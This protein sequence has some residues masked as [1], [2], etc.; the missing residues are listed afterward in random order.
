MFSVQEIIQ[1][2]QAEPLHIS[3]PNTL[4]KHLLT[5]SR[6]AFF[7]EHTLFIA[8]KG[9][10]HNAHTF[11]PYLIEKGITNFLVSENIFLSS[12]QSQS[13]NLLKVPNTLQAL[14]QIAQAH[15]Q[16]FDYPVIAITGS[17]GKTIVK[18]WLTEL[19]SP[20][21]NVVKS[22]KSYNSQVG[23]PLSVWHMTH[24]H[25]LAIFEAGISMPN[26]MQ[27]LQ[28]ILQPDIGIFTNIGEAH[29]EGF[30]NRTHKIYEKY[31]LFQH[32]PIVFSINQDL[33]AQKLPKL[34][35]NFQVIS[36]TTSAQKK[37]YTEVKFLD[38]QQFLHTLQIPFLDK[39][40]VENV[41]T[42]LCIWLHFGL[43]VSDFQ[44][45]IANLRALPMRLEAK[46]ALN[47]CLLVDDSYNNDLAGLKIA[48]DFLQHQ[49]KKKREPIFILSD[50]L[51]ASH[52]SEVLYQNIAQLLQQYAPYQLIA[53]GKEFSRQSIFFPE[54]SIFFEDVNTFLQSKIYKNFEN[55][56]ILLKGARK[57]GFE[58]IAQALTSQQH[59]TVLEVNLEA[60]VHNLNFHR[61]LLKPETKI[62]VMVKAFAYGS[63]IREVASLLQYHLVDYLAVAYADEGVE[64]RQNGIHLP[65]V[66]LNS[67][68]SDFE[69]ILTYQLEP[70]L[71]SPTIW[72]KWL[73]FLARHADPSQTYRLHI[74]I[75]T[76][77]RRLGFDQTQYEW[78]LD[79]LA[80][81]P[82]YVKVAS[83]FSHLASAED[84]ASDEFT[85][86]QIADFEQITKRIQA[87]LP[88]P[89]LRHI[90]NSAGMARF[91]EA[92]LDMV[93]LGISL[94]G[95]AP[96]PH[97]KPYLQPVTTLKTVISQ[98][99]YLSQG[100]SIGY[101]QKGKMLKDGKIG[102]IAI[103]YAD[104]F[105]RKLSNGIGKVWVNGKTAPVIGNICMD[106]TMIDLTDIEA[107]E[108]DEVIIFGKNFTIDHLAQQL[109]TIPYEVLTSIHPRVKRVFYMP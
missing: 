42:C 86:K 28:A 31:T 102:V 30:L 9:S 99:K 34:H 103:G 52:E 64:L 95:I 77:M 48:L 66:V 40:S 45:K 32:T 8:L 69:N 98:I 51:E 22:P 55:A 84:E 27:K 73:H 6:Q 11:I 5:D 29:D 91:P 47:Q 92:H 15:R 36:L 23:V 58:R 78:L 87:I 38:K 83:V 46:P 17:N 1:I 71:Y 35:A 82:T 63:G 37:H 12:L 106:M 75:D 25:N 108:G 88:Y 62:M 7:P 81:L 67:Q 97:F 16:K 90:A 74:E 39:A 13:L 10:N 96:H 85:R 50:M 109:G 54:K 44:A 104:G 3:T 59:S 53:I 43:P 21:F 57:F 79:S 19:L 49:P 33:L 107:Q 4:I 61:S 26:E 20:Y 24:K 101:N 93:R 72:Q 60:L 41:L 100:E 65:I 94:Y 2:T 76:G 18:E 70:I 105:N 89:F 14:Q 80:Q 56:Q 68:E